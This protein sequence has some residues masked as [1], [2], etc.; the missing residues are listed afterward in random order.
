M[1]QPKRLERELPVGPRRRASKPPGFQ[2]VP[3][4]RTDIG[5][6]SGQIGAH[7]PSKISSGIAHPVFEASRHSRRCAGIGRAAK[8]SSTAG[9]RAP[10]AIRSC[11]I[12]RASAISVARTK[13]RLHCGH[14]VART[15]RAGSGSLSGIVGN[16]RR[17]DQL[18]VVV[19]RAVRSSPSHSSLVEPLRPAWPSCSA[20]LAD[21]VCVRGRSR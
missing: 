2:S 15:S 8:R 19:G 7:R 14:V 16:G 1:S 3:E 12:R 13:V 21:S 20:D 4:T 5:L 18:P 11:R 17:R 10:C 9:S 6:C